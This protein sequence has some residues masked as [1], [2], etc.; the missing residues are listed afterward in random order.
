MYANAETRL[1]EDKS[2]VQDC[3]ADEYTKP[4][5]DILYVPLG[6]PWVRVT[7]EPKI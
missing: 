5:P 7:G 1:R 6:L 3:T 2:L 4:G